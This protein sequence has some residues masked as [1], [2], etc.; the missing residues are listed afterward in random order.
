MPA[1]QFWPRENSPSYARGY[2]KFD[3]FQDTVKKYEILLMKIE[4]DWLLKFYKKIFIDLFK[5]L[6]FCPQKS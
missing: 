5:S 4:W 6:P 3:K 2:Q 1:E